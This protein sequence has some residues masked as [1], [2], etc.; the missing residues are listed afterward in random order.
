MGG[1]ED[2]VAA[3]RGEEVPPGPVT[4]PPGPYDRAMD[5]LVVRHAIA[6]DREA[7]ARTGKDD[8]ERPTT[9]AG[10]Q[11]FKR[12]ARGLR[13]LVGSIDLLATSPLMRAIETGDILQKAFGIERAARLAELAPDTDPEALVRWLG[14][15]KRKEVVA[16]VGHEPHLSG[17]V[18]HLLTGQRA[19]FVDL[20]KGGAC[21]VALGDG[22]APGHAA[23]RWL[24]TAAQLRKLAR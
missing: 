15:Q 16:V 7:F 8:A 13:E 19:G 4:C 23:L 5:L 24:L 11:K 22:Q 12:G 6:E 2:V 3:D 1:A 10:R 20:K 9:P 21:L 14:R 17:L 18:E